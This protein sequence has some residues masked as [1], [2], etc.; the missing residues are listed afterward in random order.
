MAPA[1]FFFDMLRQWAAS[2]TNAEIVR[3]V[4]V[5][6]AELGRRPVPDDATVDALMEAA[7][8]LV[9]KGT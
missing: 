1:D 5:L 7:E 9:D 6:G 2:A 3:A 8:R 4:R